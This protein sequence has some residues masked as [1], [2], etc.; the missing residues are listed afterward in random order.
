MDARER[1]PTLGRHGIDACGGTMVDIDKVGVFLGLDVGK[2]THHGHGL[3]L[4]GK[5]V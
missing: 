3:T 2:H 1:L 4:A 5:K